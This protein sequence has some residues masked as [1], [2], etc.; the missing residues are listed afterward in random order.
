MGKAMNPSPRFE[1]RHCRNGYLE[2][3]CETFEK[4]RRYIDGYKSEFGGTFFIVDN[5]LPIAPDDD[6]IVW[7]D[8]EP[9]PDAL[10]Y[11]PLKSEF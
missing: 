9:S 6:R 3:V 8:A 1:V 7:R 4:S 2:G 5:A 10:Q 11:P